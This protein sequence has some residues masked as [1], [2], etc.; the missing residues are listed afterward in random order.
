MKVYM[1]RL[2]KISLCKI[3]SAAC[4]NC[5]KHSAAGDYAGGKILKLILQRIFLK[6]AEYAGLGGRGG[7]SVF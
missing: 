2:R 3:F 1:R 4:G 7:L 5:A 6:Y